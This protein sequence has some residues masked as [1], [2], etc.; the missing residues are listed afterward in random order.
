VSLDH[1]ENFAKDYAGSL[2]CQASQGHQ[3]AQSIL[4]MRGK[5]IFDE[6]NCRNFLSHNAK[7]E[8]YAVE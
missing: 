7:A 6:F 4:L 2:K 3:H 8:R 1:L 5:R